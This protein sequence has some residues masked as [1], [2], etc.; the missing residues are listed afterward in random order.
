MRSASAPA[1]RPS[2]NFSALDLALQPSDKLVLHSNFT[3]LGTLIYPNCGSLGIMNSKSATCPKLDG[4]MLSKRQKRRARV[5]E[6]EVIRREWEKAEK[7]F[8]KAK[9]FLRKL[10]AS[11]SVG[12][13]N[14]D[15]TW[16]FL[17][18]SDSES[19]PEF[20]PDCF[21]NSTCPGS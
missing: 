18:E 3:N 6:T 20:H 13:P 9:V 15:S 5:K 1:P 12:T 4:K 10:A 11:F 16:D 2:S 7:E 8:V 17:S 19:G 21:I 14:G